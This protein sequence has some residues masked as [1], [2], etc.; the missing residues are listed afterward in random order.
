[1]TATTSHATTLGTPRKDWRT[2]AACQGIDEEVVFSERPT[3]QTQMQG[4]CRGCPVKTVCLTDALGYEATEYM[5]WGVAGGLTDTQRRA[6]RVEALLGNVPNLEQAGKLTRPVFAEFM[7][8][9]RDWPAETVAEELRRHGVIAAPV[10]VRVALWWTGARAGVLP[11]QAEEDRR[12][13]WAV[14]RDECRDV[15]YRLR[16][17]GVSNLGVA[18]YLGVSRDALERA[19]RSWR[20]EGLEVAA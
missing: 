5:V 12:G 15:V 8:A 9:W 14:V 10:T 6:L 7:R 3:M 16:D 1:M 19:I 18:A 11:P 13:S 2:S 20:A 17:L 4:I